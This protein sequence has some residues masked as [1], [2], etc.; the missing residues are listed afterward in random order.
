MPNRLGDAISPYLRSH[1]DNPVD[2]FGWGADAFAEA[3]ARD[4]PVLVSIGYSTCHWCH[5]MA[6]ESF[7]DA[8]VA[9]QINAGFVAIKVDREEHPDVDGS[10]LAAAGAFTDQL[11]WPLNVFVTPEGKAFYAGTYWPPTPVGSHPSF[12]QVL[13]AVTDAWVARRDEV[14]SNADTVAAAIVQR[15]PASADDLP[16]DFSAVVAELVAH[17]DR[18]FGGFGGA[19]KFPVAPVIR[20]L[21][22]RGTQGSSDARALA[23]RTLNAMSASDLRDPV[24]GGFFRYSTRRDW[25]DPHYERML[26]DN[27][28]LLAAY[29]RLDGGEEVTAGIAGFLVDILSVDILNVDILSVDILNVDILNVDESGRDDEIGVGH[30]GAGLIG[31]FG[32]AQ[33]SESNVDGQRT[34]GGY[35]RLDAE[36]RALQH[37]PALDRKV[38]TGWNGLAIEALADAG[39]R[40]GRTEWVEAARTAADALLMAHRRSNG[41]LVRA[42]IDWRVSA[43]VATLE[44][45]GMFAAGLL[46]VALASGEVGYAVAARELID[47]CLDS[48]FHSG[49][50][51]GHS[52]GTSEAVSPPF[53][54]P[55]GG[56]PVLSAQG[57]ILD[58]DPSEGAYP[59]GLSAIADAARSLYL[60]TGELRYL[61]A[62]TAAMRTFAPLAPHRPLAFGAALS[63]MSALAGPVEQLVVVGVPDPEMAMIAQRWDS[64]GAVVAIVDVTQARLFEESG[65]ELFAGRTPI[66]GHAAAYLCRDFVCRLPVTEAS[67][68]APLLLPRTP[69]DHT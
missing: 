8:A 39:F 42:S 10:Y 9:A 22:D 3:V 17:E 50:D 44:D 24:E 64:A 5:V 51:S 1:A 52:A 36:A 34:E 6:R 67:A 58:A 19:P 29:S 16:T 4:V 2:W 33:D 59:S 45:Y 57:L 56:D 11:G 49:L 12:R 15:R 31:V 20:F 18:Q 47:A 23:S 14:L 13:D 21:Q 32:S 61:D 66:D 65:F 35:Y 28:M 41:T 40:H 26:Y 69:S 62:A 53:R 38:L 46:R 60:L 30:A 48:G 43:A 55:G 63:V 37:P 7:S 25:T 27:A 54:V 68:L